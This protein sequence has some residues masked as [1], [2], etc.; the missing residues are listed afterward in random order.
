V[1]PE[2][3]V[4]PARTLSRARVLFLVAALYD[5]VLGVAFFLLY[6]PIYAALG[7]ALPD[8]TGYIHLLS[9]FVFV[10][11]VGYWLVYRNPVRNVDLALVGAVYKVVFA[12]VAIGYAVFSELPDGIFLVFGI[13]DLGFLVA[14]LWFVRAVYSAEGRLGKTRTAVRS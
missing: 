12:G 3:A 9:G 10:Q 6:D 11:G 1:Q 5:L 4:L 2:L 8:N 14:F 13:L 7:A